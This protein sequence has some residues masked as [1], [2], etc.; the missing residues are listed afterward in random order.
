ML[1]GIFSLNPINGVKPFPDAHI[2]MIVRTVMVFK[3]E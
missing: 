1:K 3:I 2:L